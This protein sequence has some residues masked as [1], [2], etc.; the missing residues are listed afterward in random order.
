MSR[1]Q[2]GPTTEEL[3]QKLT[4]EFEEYKTTTDENIE[5]YKLENQENIERFNTT[6][7]ENF[8]KLNVNIDSVKTE[9]K[10]DVE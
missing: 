10:K 1:R 9:Y 4:S 3:L 5:R 2:K 8:E 7:V 6:S